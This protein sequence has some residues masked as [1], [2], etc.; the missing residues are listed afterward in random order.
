MTTGLSLETTS[1]R[2][3]ASNDIGASGVLVEHC[4]IP[5]Q[6]KVGD[7]SLLTLDEVLTLP[8]ERV[9]LDAFAFLVEESKMGALELFIT[10]Q[11]A[12][13]VE[14]HRTAAA[15][16]WENIAR[17]PTNSVPGS[18]SRHRRQCCRRSA[19]IF[20]QAERLDWRR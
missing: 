10:R 18:A 13:C 1:T 3:L 20:G 5:A 8:W 7:F 17:T 11:F 19:D 12:A 4:G 15:T 16:G 9:E 2:Q 6:A 14:R